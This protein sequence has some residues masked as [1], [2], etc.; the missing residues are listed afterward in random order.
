MA[1]PHRDADQSLP[2]GIFFGVP[3]VSL[4]SWHFYQSMDSVRGLYEE[5]DWAETPV[6]DRRMPR[7]RAIRRSTGSDEDTGTEG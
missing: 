5:A 3:T 4:R 7:L 1:K 2:G 6:A